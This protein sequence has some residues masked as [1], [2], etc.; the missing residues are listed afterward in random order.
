MFN[1]YRRKDWSF[2]KEGVL[3]THPCFW[4]FIFSTLCIGQ[5][6]LVSGV[7]NPTWESLSRKRSLF[8]P[9][10]GKSRS[11]VHLQY[12][13]IKDTNNIRALP[14]LLSACCYILE[15]LAIFTDQVFQIWRMWTPVFQASHTHYLQ[16]E[17]QKGHTTSISEKNPWGRL[18]LAQL[19]S[20]S[21]R[22]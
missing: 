15:Y 5:E 16:S 6:C 8:V 2:A 21:S 19:E 13:Y 20:L 9:L 1:K 10:T 14:S 3:S 12:D 18:W 22:V 7:Q 17:R 11:E 4:S